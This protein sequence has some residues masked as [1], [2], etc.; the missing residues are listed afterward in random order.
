MGHSASGISLAAPKFPGQ[1]TMR[2]ADQVIEEVD[3]QLTIQ[4]M[5][6]PDKRPTAQSIFA[7]HDEKA[8]TRSDPIDV[9]NS[10]PSMYLPF[11]RAESVR[12]TDYEPYEFSND[13]V[14]STSAPDTVHMQTPTINV[15]N[16]D[17]LET[18]NN[19]KF[20]P[21]RSKFRANQQIAH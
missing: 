4:S 13:E 9:P 19:K 8:P 17:D 15:D 14:F 12:Q 11:D 18:P 7:K 1:G 3:E 6:A 21:A 20:D 10:H 16:F 2:I 5:R